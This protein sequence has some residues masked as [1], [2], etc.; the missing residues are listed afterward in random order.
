MQVVDE[1]S[2]KAEQ[3]P[4]HLSSVGSVAGCKEIHS[5]ILERSKAEL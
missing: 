1:R 5:S 3:H 4:S 2:L